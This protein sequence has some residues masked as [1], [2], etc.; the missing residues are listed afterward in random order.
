VTQSDAPLGLITR[1]A[2]EL[3]DQGVSYCHWKSNAS[4]DR[5]LAGNGDLDLLIG[6]DSIGGFYEVLGRLRF[7]RA[8]AKG[9]PSVPG[10]EHFYGYD[11]DADLFVHIHAHFQMILGHDRTKN[12]HLP[13]EDAYLNASWLQGTMRL[14]DPN[15]EYI[16][17]VI[18]MTLKYSI[19]DEILWNALLGRTTQPKPGEREEFKVLSQQVDPDKVSKLL[20][21]HFP[22]LDEELFD[23]CV[24]IL[25]SKPT[26]GRRLRTVHRLQQSLSAHGRY[27]P[28][29]DVGLR[30]WRRVAVTLRKRVGG[31]RAQR[32]S[33]GGAIIAV[34]GGD[35]AGKSTALDE[36]YRWLRREFDVRRIHLGKPRW[37]VTTVLVRGALQALSTIV[38]VAAGSRRNVVESYRPVFWMVCKARDRFHTYR[39]AR[40]FTTNGGLVVS[41]RYPHPSLRL[42]DA[43]QIERM[44]EDE[45]LDGP[46]VRRMM[47]IEQKYHDAI[48]LPELVVALRVDPEIAV[49]RKTTESP[50]S[51]RRRGNEI[52]NMTWADGSVRVIDA[53]KSREEVARE[54]KSMIWSRLS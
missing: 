43:P 5:A 24:D 41:D 18:R 44:I 26:I 45:T 40:R 10:T 22:Y 25:R 54:L 20:A 30:L 36:V 52:W 42:M 6:R 1:L 48:G 35:G 7:V 51:V 32:L 50:E 13:I 29:I 11:E 33:T 46:L 12:Y 9:R 17:F 37:S 53:S 3:D 38:G 28:A 39:K 34:I 23:R 31:A 14:P 15:F 19:W 2:R 49:Q 16:V 47:R 4:I 8:E 27:A 21:E